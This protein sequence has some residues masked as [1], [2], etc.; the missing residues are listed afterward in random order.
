MIDGSV[1][2]QQMV[3]FSQQSSDLF[4]KTVST[5]R[6]MLTDA[7]GRLALVTKTKTSQ[8]KVKIRWVWRTHE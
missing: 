8:M 1:V 3:L 7:A 6:E 4:K 5:R 2:G